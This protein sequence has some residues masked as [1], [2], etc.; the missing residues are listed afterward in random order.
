MKTMRIFSA[1]IIATAIFTACSSDDD[2]TPRGNE[3]TA[4]NFT[5]SINGTVTK[6]A[7]DTW[8]AGD[9]IGVFMKESGQPLATGS[10][11]EGVDNY[12][13]T[14]NAAGQG[15]VGF[16]AA[17]ANE[18]AFFPQTGTVDFISYYPY[19]ASLTNYTYAINVSNQNPQSAIDLLYSNNVTGIDRTTP[20]VALQF[21]HKLTKLLFNIQPGDGVTAAELAALTVTINGMNT[22][23]S[24]NL[25]NAAITGLGTPATITA[26]TTNNGTVSEAIII[27]T[28][29]TGAS[30]SFALNNDDADVFTWNIPAATQFLPGN[31]H[32]YTVTITRTGMSIT[33]TITNW[34]DINEPPVV[35]D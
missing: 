11:S 7:N 23:A 32:I 28:S 24:Y 15:P 16:T 29:A 17:D 1:F 9:A 20:T 33:G 19:Q 10:I 3:P 31:R 30:V 21:S 27:P 4:V 35:A 5:S 25:A 2:G 12:E 34:N 6:A 13:Y 8:A 18:V 26:L 14:A 22:T